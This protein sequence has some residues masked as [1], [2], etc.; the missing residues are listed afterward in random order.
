MSKTKLQEV[1]EYM[2]Q[3]KEDMANTLSKADE[4]LK[5]AEKKVLAA[6]EEM[7]K[8]TEALDAVAYEKAKAK[9][10]RAAGSV[11]MYRT[12]CNQIVKK[13]Y[14]PEER[15]DAIIDDLLEYERELDAKFRE[16]ITS[17]VRALSDLCFKYSAEIED[18]ERTLELW[19]YEI[20]PNYKDRSNNQRF[21]S[22]IKVHMFAYRGSD[23]CSATASYLR[24]APIEKI[25]RD[26]E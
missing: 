2:C 6:T 15:S 4:M 13:G 16:D 21:S 17:H 24:K 26:G 12:R 5:D 22:P 1:K 3:L 18:T 10:D 8:A 11:E 7:N 14:L 9:R 19:Q 25:L 20:H 23:E